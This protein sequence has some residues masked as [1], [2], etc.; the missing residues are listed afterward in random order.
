MQG[1]IL[2]ENLISGNDGNRY[3][4]DISDVENLKGE[5]MQNIVGREVDFQVQENMAKSIF[6]AQKTGVGN[7]GELIGDNSVQGIR[8]KGYCSLMIY[9]WEIPFLGQIL[10]ILGVLASILV[11]VSIQKVSG[12]TTLFRNYIIPLL[13]YVIA[14]TIMVFSVGFGA[15][16]SMAVGS[17]GA[18]NFEMLLSSFGIGT[19]VSIIMFMV[20]IYFKYQ[21]AKELV[22][23]TNQPYFLYAFFASI[24][25]AVTTTILIGVLFFIAA[26]ILEIMAWNR[27]SEIR[28]A[29]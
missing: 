4:F 10:A 29:D 14:G 20:A 16:A 19:I 25:G 27:L 21:Y 24:I 1:K 15:F 9:L 28:K 5:S 3:K 17:S 18:P 12:S 26:L 2:A 7:V 13:L 23:I 8:I 22:T 6:L 11:V